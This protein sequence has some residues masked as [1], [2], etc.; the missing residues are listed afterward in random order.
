VLLVESLD[1]F[2]MWRS[3]VPIPHVLSY[4]RAILGF[5]QAVI[6]RVPRTRFRLFDQQLNSA[7][8][9]RLTNSL[10]LSE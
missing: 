1:G 2:G 7:S 4:Y 10:P 6:V 9:V 5:S 8:T 3:N